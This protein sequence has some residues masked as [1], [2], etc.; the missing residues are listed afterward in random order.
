MVSNIMMLGGRG[1]EK[2][3]HTM[4]V[5]VSIMF[6]V[7]P[8]QTEPT[9]IQTVSANGTAASRLTPNTEPDRA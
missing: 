6:H 2:R 4:L 7:T 1:R 3:S 5:E 8:I 9:F